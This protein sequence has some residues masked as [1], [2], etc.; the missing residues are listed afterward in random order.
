MDTNTLCFRFSLLLVGWLCIPVAWGQQ[1]QVDYD[2]SRIGFIA[3]YDE[4]P[5]EASF[6]DFD[7][8]VS[9]DPSAIDQASFKV[10]VS[11]ASVDSNSADRD[12]GMLE[13]DW[14]DTN[15]HPYSTFTSTIFKKM[16]SEDVF[17][18]SG[19]L[20]I[21]GVSQPIEFVFSWKATGGSANL[22]GQTEVNRT[23]FLIGS[24][25]WAEDDT[26]GF[27]VQIIFDLNL[28]KS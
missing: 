9:F 10:S 6:K 12:E 21:K 1:W 28:S 17:T 20:L 7:A 4:I 23:D 18:V 14:F 5:F 25:D 15:Q 8:D 19:E 27:D 11:I 22:Q 3:S 26:I 16:D 2:T 24:G 13:A